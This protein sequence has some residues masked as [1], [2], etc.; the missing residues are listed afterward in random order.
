MPSRLTSAAALVACG[1]LML[2]TT[3]QGGGVDQN[4]RVRA[5]QDC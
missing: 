5:L 4:F 3:C 2:S 1:L